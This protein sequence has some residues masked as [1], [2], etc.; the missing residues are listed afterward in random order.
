MPLTAVDFPVHDKSKWLLKREEGIVHPLASGWTIQLPF[1]LQAA[2]GTVDRSVGRLVGQ[3]ATSS[4]STVSK[5]KRIFLD[6]DIPDARTF[7]IESRGLRYKMV[8]QTPITAL[9]SV[10][11][12][13][14]LALTSGGIGRG[15]D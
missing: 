12:T 14:I 6:K 15:L 3:S 2:D 1:L 5:R 10:T 4:S 13:R 8:T 9:N 11:Q 7:W